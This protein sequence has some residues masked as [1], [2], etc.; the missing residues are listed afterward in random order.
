MNSQMRLGEYNEELES[1][2]G[3]FQLDGMDYCY[4]VSRYSQRFE[5]R[6]WPKGKLVDGKGAEY[7]GDRACGLACLRMIFSHYGKTVPSQYELL[8]QALKRRAYSPKGWIHQGLADLG[9]IYGLSA[10]SIA[11]EN[12]TQLQ[13]VLQ[14]TGPLIVSITHKF[15]EDGRRGGHL[16]VV[17]GRHKGPEPTITFRDPSRWGANN[18]TVSEKRFFSSFSKRAICFNPE[19]QK[20]KKAISW[21]EK[22]NKQ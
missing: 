5:L 15:P 22:Y 14:I 21:L 8:N 3:L 1:Y 6:E 20:V 13:L 17:C 4:N 10:A 19:A 16:V 7:W 9:E 11:I 2:S 12:A 18:S